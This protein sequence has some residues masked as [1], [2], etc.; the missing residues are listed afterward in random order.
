MFGSA[1]LG[2]D[3]AVAMVAFTLSDGVVGDDTG[4]D[5]IIIDQGNPGVVDAPSAPALAW[6]AFPI[7]ILILAGI[8]RHRLP[9]RPW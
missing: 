9:R 5:G 1:D 8:A 3:P 6:W 4:D 7:L 2:F